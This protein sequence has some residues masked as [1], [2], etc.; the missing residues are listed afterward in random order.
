MYLF[1]AVLCRGPTRFTATLLNG[2]SIIDRGI[3]AA[4]ILWAWLPFW[5]CGH[6]ALTSRSIPGQEKCLWIWLWF[7]WNPSELPQAL[8]AQTHV[9]LLVLVPQ[10]ESLPSC[11]W[12]ISATIC[13]QQNRGCLTP[14]EELASV[15]LLLKSIPP[16]H[17]LGCHIPYNPVDRSIL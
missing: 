11:Q 1:P 13:L 12:C 6:Y 17:W 3:K 16:V 8:H 4:F 7:F 14:A 5:H 9:S 2:S 15:F 10:S